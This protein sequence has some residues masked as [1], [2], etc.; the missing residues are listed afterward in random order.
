MAEPGILGMF[1]VAKRTF[2]FFFKERRRNKKFGLREKKIEA[3]AFKRS[4]EKKPQGSKV[5]FVSFEDFF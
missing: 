3:K 2:L 1:F 5:G 4:L